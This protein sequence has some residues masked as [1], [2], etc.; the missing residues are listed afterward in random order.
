M[1][2]QFGNVVEIIQL[3]YCIRPYVKT[4]IRSFIS[5]L[6]SSTLCFGQQYVLYVPTYPKYE[7]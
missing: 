7:V 2:E 5:N 6:Q 4:L 3:L 1:I